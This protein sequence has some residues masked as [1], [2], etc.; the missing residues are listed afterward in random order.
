MPSA[1]RSQ[2]FCSS[3]LT[4]FFG[5][6]FLL[7]R[8]L[9]KVATPPHSFFLLEKRIPALR[10]SMHSLLTRLAVSR[11]RSTCS[12]FRFLTKSAQALFSE[13]PRQDREYAY[14][15]LQELYR[16][17]ISL[18]LRLGHKIKT[19]IIM[20]VFILCPRQESNLH[21]IL[22]TDLFYPL[23]YKGIQER[24]QCPLSLLTVII[25]LCNLQEC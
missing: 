3:S 10:S 18:R 22:R 14:L 20:G 12:A 16:F 13:G 8:R 4:K 1:G 7:D 5:H 2:I 23:N 9:A 19:P 25:V 15:S 11:A 24:G 6:N 21:L 17:R